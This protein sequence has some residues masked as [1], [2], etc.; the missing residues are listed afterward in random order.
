MK[1]LVVDQYYYPEEFQINDICEQMVKDGHDVTVLTGLPNYPTGVIPEEYK[2]GKKRDENINGVRVIRSYEIGRKKGA[3]G[4]IKNYMSFAVSASFKQRKLPKDFD[5]VFIYETSPVT[6]AIPGELYARRRKKPVFFY[7]CDIWPECAKVMIKNEKS[8]MYKIIKKW[9][10]RI[11][12]K[13]DIIALQTEGFYDYFKTV[14]GIEEGRLRYLPQFA[15]SEYLE[16]DFSPE[17]N[18]VIDFV[19]TGNVGI[20]QDIGGLIKAVDSIRDT[21]GF[22][23]HIVGSGSFLEEAEKLTKE[24]HLED[25]IA[26]YGRRPY[27]EMPQ[28]YKLADVCLATLQADSLLSL[29]MPSKVQGYMAAGKPILAAVSGKSREIIETNKCGLCITPGDSGELGAA[30][31]DYIDHYEKYRDY[32]INGREYFKRNFTKEIF[33]QRLY[34]QLNETMRSRI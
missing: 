9:S 31:K 24:K 11:Y 10:T 4:M 26:F 29:T 7:C 32:G 16:M 23:V 25:L 17:D 13:A 27:D 6:L 12:R 5:I 20:A 15:N 33:M 14:H 3:M 18:G 22:K 21:R 8:L 1:I 19:F 30:M 28:F 2:H 34:S